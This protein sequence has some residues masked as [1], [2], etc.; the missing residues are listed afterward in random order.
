MRNDGARQ[1]TSKLPGIPPAKQKGCEENRV[2]TDVDLESVRGPTANSLDD[3]GWYTGLCKCSSTT[4]SQRVASHIRGK[5]EPQAT[6]EPGASRYR[7]VSTQPE[8][9]VE[10]EKLVTGGEVF[11]K[12]CIGVITR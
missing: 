6:D 9:R 7:T 2:L 8:F 12:W 1:D 3:M 4:C 5:V 10:R 11:A